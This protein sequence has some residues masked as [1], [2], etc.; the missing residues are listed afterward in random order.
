MTTHPT[1]TGPTNPPPPPRLDQ[2]PRPMRSVSATIAS[3]WWWPSPPTPGPAGAALPPL[4][5]PGATPLPTLGMLIRDA[6]RLG[7]QMIA[8]LG[9]QWDPTSGP[10]E[11]FAGVGLSDVHLS[12]AVADVRSALHELAKLAKLAAWPMPPAGSAVK[13][14]RVGSGEM[15]TPGSAAAAGHTARESP[16][17]APAPG[18]GASSGPSSHHSERA[19]D[20][21]RRGAGPGVLGPQRQVMPG[22]AALARSI[23]EAL[24]RRSR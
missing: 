5:D 16:G 11:D 15:P 10:L 20:D 22:T 14:T 24:A 9:R 4:A 18:A 19:S 7:Q 8:V 2:L 3:R 21:H 17:G 23:N 13:T 6:E 12:Q 1:P